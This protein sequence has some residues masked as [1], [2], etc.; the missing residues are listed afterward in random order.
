MHVEMMRSMLIGQDILPPSSRNRLPELVV[1]PAG[2]FQ[3]H[4]REDHL[5]VNVPARE[6]FPEKS[7]SQLKQGQ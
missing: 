1:E 6:A 4:S 5:M 7:S 3:I 2:H